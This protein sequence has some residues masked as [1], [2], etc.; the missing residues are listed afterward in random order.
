LLWEAALAE[1][2]NLNMLERE[3]IANALYVGVREG[4]RSAYQ[5]KPEWAD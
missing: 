2:S 4:G 1:E 3:F 5:G